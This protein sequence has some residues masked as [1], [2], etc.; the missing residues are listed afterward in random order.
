L[1]TPIFSYYSKDSA[2]LEITPVKGDGHDTTPQYFLITPK[3]LPNLK[4]HQSKATVMTPVPTKKLEIC[5]QS[6]K[7][8]HKKSK[9][10]LV[11]LDRTQN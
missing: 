10:S 5:I 6:Q 11:L 4:S 7:I 8:N 2:E 9:L 3:I 1:H